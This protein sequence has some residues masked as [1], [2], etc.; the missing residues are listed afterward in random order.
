MS[1][2]AFAPASAWFTLPAHVQSRLCVC[3][4]IGSH[5]AGSAHVTWMC[6]GL[7]IE[8]SQRN[9]HRTSFDTFPNSHSN[10][11]HRVQGSQFCA[12]TLIVVFSELS[13]KQIWLTVKCRRFTQVSRANPAQRRFP[14]IRSRSRV[15]LFRCNFRWNLPMT[16]VQ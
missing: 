9:R 2:R 4:I 7:E 12:E 14:S 16:T 13:T 3:G 15:E 6:H 1:F 8:R 5:S 10:K 11:R